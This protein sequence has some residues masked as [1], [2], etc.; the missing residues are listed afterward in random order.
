[1]PFRRCRY[2]SGPCCGEP[3]DTCLYAGQG[4]LRPA[5]KPSQCRGPPSTTS[6]G[7]T[8][9]QPVLVGWLRVTIS[10]PR[11][12][13]SLQGPPLWAWGFGGE[14]SL[15]GTA[16]SYQPDSCPLAEVQEMFTHQILIFL[17]HPHSQ[18]L[19][20]VPAALSAFSF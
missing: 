14:L 17:G 19:D 18:L 6:W 12:P 11:Q 9:S 10:V 3:S 16:A 1:M 4:P 8:S 15:S 13:L 5:A 7:W 20:S 2:R